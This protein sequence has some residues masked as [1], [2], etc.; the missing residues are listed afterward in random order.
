[1]PKLMNARHGARMHAGFLSAQAR[2]FLACA[3]L[4][5]CVASVAAQEE[6]PETKHGIPVRASQEVRVAGVVRDISGARVANAEVRL[7]FIPSDDDARSV[8]TNADGEFEFRIIPATFDSYTLSVTAPGFAHYRRRL[9][10]Q[11]TATLEIVLTPAAISEE[12]IVSAARTGTRLSDTPASVVLINREE[13]ATTAA[14]N[15]D[16]VLRQVP[17]FQ[18][19]RRTSS[20]TANPTT[21]GVSLRGTGASGAS[22]ALVLADGVPLTDPFGGWVY[23]GR[24]PRTALGRI[25]VLRGAASDLYGSSALGGVVALERR[26][27]KEPFTLSLETSIGTQATPEGSL[28]LGGRRGQW[29]VSIAAEAFR[30]HGYIPVAEAARGA[31]DARAASRRM[32]GEVTLERFFNGDGSGNRLFIRAATYNEKRLNG[33]FLQTNR[34]GIRSFSFGAD[35]SG[36][37]FDSY[38]L[39]LYGGTQTYDQTFSS[40]ALDR[41]SETLTRRQRVPAQVT[42]ASAQGSRVVASRHTLVGGFDAREVRGASDEIIFANNRAS[43]LVGAGGREQTFGLFASD[44]SRV[45]SRLILSGSI[46]FDRWHNY[47][48][49]SAT[50]SLIAANSTL[51]KFPERGERAFSPR[52]S[53]LFQLTSNVS[54]AASASRAFRQPTLNEL[55]R[56][57]R[58]GNIL[59]LANENLRAERAKNYEAGAVF[60]FFDRRLTA[61]TTLYQV[62]IARPVANVTLTATPTLIT[63]QRQNLGRTRSRGFEAEAEARLA[64]NLT[65]SGGYL[66]ADPR[67]VEF[68]AAPELENLFLPQV[69]RH[70]GT[71][72]IRYA[73]PRLLTIGLQGRALGRQFDDDQ[74]LLP[75]RPFFTLDALVARRLTSNL[76]AFAAAENLTNSRYDIGRTPVLTIASPVFVRFGVRLRFGVE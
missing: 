67:V 55:Y 22:R 39:R 3:L 70:Q 9:T 25:E 4:L 34:T 45:G 53:A 17:G 66:F 20:R 47:R 63:R 18:L 29:G 30:T 56:A 28:W 32:S 5:I 74:N 68:P 61:R 37:G 44:I 19:F 76:E 33:T 42:G 57:F 43:S 50:R 64:N 15:V 58:V 35:G 10:L 73:N 52:G 7:E 21:Q 8:M 12:V 36:R 11:E 72:Q 60:N 41:N 26:T 38:A 48:A 40:I 23:W 14:T 13:L 69:A 2:L 49:L 46:R 75:L 65:L 1:M 51:I 27:T 71:F 6:S 54:L 24:V 62:G 31:V 16:D 59:T